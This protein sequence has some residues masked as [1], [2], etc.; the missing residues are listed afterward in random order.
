M[1]EE[2]AP[3]AQ[4]VEPIRTETDVEIDNLKKQ[5]ANLQSTVKE[6]QDANRRLYAHAIGR[7]EPDADPTPA[8]PTYDA[9]QAVFYKSLGLKP[10]E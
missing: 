10:E 2:P 1:P 9:A 7:Q 5:L 6:Y 3:D 4:P 8:P